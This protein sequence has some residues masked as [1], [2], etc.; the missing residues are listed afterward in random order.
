MRL[1]IRF[2]T[3]RIETLWTQVLVGFAYQGPGGGHSGLPEGLEDRAG[4]FL[5]GLRAMGFW[6]G[7][8]GETLLFPSEGRVGAQ[9]VLLKGLGQRRS[10]D[11]RVLIQMLSEAGEDLSRIA[12]LDFGVHIPTGG[13]AWEGRFS[14]M[15]E[16][17]AALIGHFLRGADR[18]SDRLVKMVF[19]AE[20]GLSEGL[21]SRAGSLRER[22][23]AGFPCSTRVDG[24]DPYPLAGRN[25]ER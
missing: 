8:L 21:V 1:D 7:E 2:T 20:P 23:S 6:R 22:F 4:G 19:C 5:H 24:K 14:Q 16:A 11:A 12:A 10:A 18:I 9:W 13:E 3:Q 17:C 15:E 25:E